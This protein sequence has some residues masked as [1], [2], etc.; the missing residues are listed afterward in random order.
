MIRRFCKT[1]F[2]VFFLLSNPAIQ[3][4][5]SYFTATVLRSYPGYTGAYTVSGAVVVSDSGTSGTINVGYVMSG[6]EADASGGIHVHEGTSCDTTSDPGGHLN[7]TYPDEWTTT[8]TSDVNGNTG[9]AF[10][11]MSY[12][13]TVC[14]GHVIVVHDTNKVRIAC[15]VLGSVPS[16]SLS[17]Y[18]DYT[19]GQNATGYIVVGQ[20]DGATS[21]LNSTTTLYYMLSNLETS[22][23]TGGLHIHSGTSC[24]S[25]AYV[26]GHF[27]NPDVED[28]WTSANGA[29]WTTT[30][31]SGSAHNMFSVQTGYD[32]TDNSD[33]VVVLHSSTFSRTSC[34]VLSASNLVE[35]TYASTEDSDSSEDS[36][37]HVI[38]AAS[39]GAAAAVVLALLIS[40]WCCSRAKK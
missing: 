36:T 28:P 5:Q 34:G 6:L 10:D 22:A 11:V 3:H 1:S 12:N 24:A 25:A 29:V 18:P 7:S 20:E 39:V 35:P 31:T 13:A 26:G 19:G 38:I 27:S 2:L 33:R 21:A 15:G 40:S 32:L 37:T 14:D 23:T 30:D 16:T 9:G 8:Y 17:N 4:V